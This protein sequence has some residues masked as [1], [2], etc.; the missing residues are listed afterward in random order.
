[1][2]D[3]VVQTSGT[4]KIAATALTATQPVE[5]IQNKLNLTHG[6]HYNNVILLKLNLQQLKLTQALSELVQIF[7][8]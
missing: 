3:S 5:K 8:P 7:F 2:A 1:V 4:T 6:T